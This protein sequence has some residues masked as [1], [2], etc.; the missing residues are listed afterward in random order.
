RRRRRNQRLD[1]DTAVSATLA[2]AGFHR[3]PL[4]DDDDDDAAAN[5]T[6]SRYSPA[7][8]NP[9]M[10]QRS[11]SALAISNRASAAFIQDHD[12]DHVVPGPSDFN[13]YADYVTPTRTDGY[14]PVPAPTAPPI[15]PFPYRDRTS[16][17]PDLVAGN[18]HTHARTT[19][20]DP[21]IPNPNNTLPPT[22]SSAAEDVPLGVEIARALGAPEASGPSSIYSQRTDLGPDARLDPGLRQRLVDHEDSADDGASLFRDEEDYSRPVLGVRNMPDTSSQTSRP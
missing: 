6:P 10:T 14:I 20:F 2:A 19:S 11:T 16:G 4:V 22:Y 1:H 18:D 3:T 15:F 9:F 21:L 17:S 5:S 8:S 7:P 12:T 13:P